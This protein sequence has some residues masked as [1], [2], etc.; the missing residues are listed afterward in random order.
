MAELLKT[1]NLQFFVVEI[2]KALIT[3]AVPV[4]I[5]A[6]GWLLSLWFRSREIKQLLMSR[7]LILY[8]GGEKSDMHKAINFLEK[9]DIGAG[10]NDNESFWKV[11]FGT[12]KILDSEK[13]VFSKF[14]WNKTKGLMVHTNDPNLPSVMG[15]YMVP[16][17][18]KK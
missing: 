3:I 15:Q 2:V 18:T 1:F 17:T 13:R 7:E 8:F 10:R 5:G 14:K 16:F 9:G 4:F 12:L 6:S 11:S